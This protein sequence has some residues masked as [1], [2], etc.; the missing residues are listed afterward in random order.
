LCNKQLDAVLF[1]ILAQ[2]RKVSV[3]IPPRRMT[4][5]EIG[6]AIALKSEQFLRDDLPLIRIRH[7]DAQ[8]LK[9][10]HL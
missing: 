1:E 3:G 9:L 5:D 8:E 2:P 7:N 10:K 4:G 6:R